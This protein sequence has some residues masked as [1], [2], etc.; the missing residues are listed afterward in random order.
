MDAVAP[1]FLVAIAGPALDPFELKP[2]ESGLTLGRHDACELLMP[3]DADR[4][5]R[6][7]ARFS[8]DGKEW[9]IA[10]L[11]SRWG[12]YLNGV[13]LSPNAE[14]PLNEGDLIRISPWTFNFSSVAKRRGMQTA[15]DIGRTMVRAVAPETARPLRDDML[16]LLLESAAAIHGAQ[17]ERELAELVMD[18]AIR[19]TN[20]HNAVMLRPI[21][22]T[23]RIEIIASKLSQSAQNSGVSFSR[24]L[25]KMASEG[26][27][28]EISGVGT[29][30]ISQ[31]MVQMQINA[32]LCVPL[33]L[34][35]A[36]AAFLYLDS[37]GAV[38]QA[39]RPNA[40]AFCVAL[41]RM[42]SLA[43]ANLKRLDIECRQA[44][45]ES[46]LRAAA[47]A[48]KWIL[49]Q[50]ETRIGSFLCLGES[51][52]GQF[53]GG[54]FFDIIDLGDNKLAI[55]VGDVSGKGIAASVLMTA[56][57]GFLHA[58]LTQHGDPG[59]AVTSL[60]E[61]VTPRRPENKFVTVWVGIFDAAASTLQYVDAGHSYAL[62]HGAD[63]NF[64]QLDSGGGLPVGVM[65]DSQYTTETIQLPPG[66]RVLVVSDGI[67]E[68]FGMV[69]KEDGTVVKDQFEL[70][71]VKRSM[72]SSDEDA[73]APLFASVIQHAGTN[74][75][76]DDA[77]VVMVKW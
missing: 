18:A 47:T 44:H 33:M 12:T 67:I 16:T 3:A 59:S 11:G 50:R 6:Y 58:A 65:A 40:S 73:M 64:T 62:L 36:P 1:K 23:G 32:A 71:G 56:A 8:L 63:G 45:I 53:V 29:G 52:P 49:P 27:V 10:D 54:D 24:S 19:G 51:R 55:T 20:L 28:A 43:L 75:L 76:S 26:S 4:V 15:D 61:F 34:G 13:K 70:K 9:R 77:T 30:D 38:G 37:R 7:H 39:L 66:G 31:S 41:G 46:E 42:A 68:Q 22:S 25:L 74:N 48:Q 69:A 21:D 57:Q 5:S 35:P 2:K 14:V 17:N 60:N 72:T